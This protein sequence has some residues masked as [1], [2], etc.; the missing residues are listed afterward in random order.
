MHLPQNYI[1][2]EG[3]TTSLA[4]SRQ[5]MRKGRMTAMKSV[6][7]L[8]KRPQTMP[9]IIGIMMASLSFTNLT[10]LR[11]AGTAVVIGIAS[12][13][14]TKVHE[15]QP[16]AGSGLDIQALKDNFKD[17]GIWLWIA[18]PLIIDAVSIA[19][20]KLFLQFEIR[21]IDRGPVPRSI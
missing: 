21:Q 9:L 2:A 17:K 19:N 4:V 15:R 10:G 7:T 20:S 8:P 18:L 1:S 14:I 3:E 16:Y 13:F 12:F 6:E 5:V 11:I